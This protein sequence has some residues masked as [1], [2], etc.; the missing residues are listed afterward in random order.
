MAYHNSETFDLDDGDLN[1][2]DIDDCDRAADLGGDDVFGPFPDDVLV[3]P[4]V[5][6]ILRCLR[7]LANE[8][9]G[10]GLKTTAAALSHSIQICAADQPPSLGSADR[11]VPSIAAQAAFRVH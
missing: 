4:M 7:M 11:L 6:G 3:D 9:T 8:A 1:D 10:L 2:G 5:L